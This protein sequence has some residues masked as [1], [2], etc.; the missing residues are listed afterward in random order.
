[1][2]QYVYSDKSLSICYTEGWLSFIEEQELK[3]STAIKLW[4][5]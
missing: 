3:L 5:S 4:N 1:M 2:S